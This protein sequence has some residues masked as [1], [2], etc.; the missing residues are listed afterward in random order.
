MSKNEIEQ[1]F[2]VLNQIAPV[3]V[4]SFFKHKVLKEIEQEVPVRLPLFSWLMPQFQLA[5]LSL[6][7]LL[8]IGTIFYVF[9]SSKETGTTTINTF[10]QEYALQT[11]T[12]SILN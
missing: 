4:S 3:K 1:T 2:S 5:T 11:S 6:V 10:A 12:N 8:N 7:L 9:S